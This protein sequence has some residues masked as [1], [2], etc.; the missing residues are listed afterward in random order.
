MTDC[1][2]GWLSFLFE[3]AVRMKRNR[4]EAE[5]MAQWIRCMSFETDTS[6]LGVRFTE[7]LRDRLRGSWLRLKR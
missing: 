7:R 4:L 6:K 3:L 5:D 2:R 1:R